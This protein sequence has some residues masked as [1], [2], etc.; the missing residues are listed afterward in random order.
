MLH[1]VNGVT[2]EP[3]TLNCAE[4]RVVLAISMPVLPPTIVFI[5][6]LRALT[7]HHCDFAKLIPGVRAVRE[8]LDWARIE[9]ETAD[10]DF[11]AAFLVLVNRLGLRD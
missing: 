4:D 10:N 9:T 7:E 6:K 3:T 8:Q 1:R 2:V 11:A 5:Q